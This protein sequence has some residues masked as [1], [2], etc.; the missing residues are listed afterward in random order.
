MKF[1][2]NQE[3][4]ALTFDDVQL[5]QQFFEGDSRSDIDL[6]MSLGKWK[7]NLPVIASN[8][9]TI[10]GENM[11]EKMN[12]LGGL[13]IIHRFMSVQEQ[14]DITSRWKL[15]SAHGNRPI[16][17]SLGLVKK[18]KERYDVLVKEKAADILCIDTAHGFQQQM[19]DSVKYLRD[20][21][22]EGILIAGNVCTHTGTWQLIHEGVD[23]VKVGIGPGS[24]CTTRIKTGCGMPQLTAIE[25]CATVVD[26]SPLYPVI[27][28]GGI[29]KPADIVK[30]MAVGASFT[31]IG[32]MLAG[33]DCVPGWEEDL[34]FINYAGNASSHTKVNFGLPD[35]NVEGI[36][37]TIPTKP[38]GSTEKVIEYIKEGLVSGLSYNGSM[39]MVEHVKKAQFVRTT[40]A[41]VHEATPHFSG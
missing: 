20:I 27:A 26:G 39:N 16:A 41:G 15:S 21:G 37:K 31:M 40:L 9:P 25:D 10:C 17:H 28:D 32:G 35:D 24:V 7:F 5:V 4:P 38:R 33:T 2:R 19:L 12:E 29:T 18:D 3:T 6:S 36:I 34:S 22:F 14:L 30:A 13:G 8:M 1:Y 23:L 11:A